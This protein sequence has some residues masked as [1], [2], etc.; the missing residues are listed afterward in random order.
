[1]SAA[2]CTPPGYPA[3]DGEA[4]A[5]GVV[6]PRGAVEAELV[7]GDPAGI[8]AVDGAL[9]V[10]DGPEF[11][12]DPFGGAIAVD[13]LGQRLGRVQVA[14]GQLKNRSAGLG[15]VPAALPGAGDPR[16]GTD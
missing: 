13:V 9:A 7:F 2:G 11:A 10:G 3:G 4:V 8:V 15:A 12:R 14:E 1:L 5:P 16:A 6:F